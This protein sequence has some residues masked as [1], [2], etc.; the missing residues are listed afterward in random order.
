VAKLRKLGK[1]N[2]YSFYVEKEM[3]LKKPLASM[4]AM[5]SMATMVLG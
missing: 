2:D 4:A 3:R 5:A 1:N